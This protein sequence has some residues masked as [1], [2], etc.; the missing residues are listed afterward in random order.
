MPLSA[1]DVIKAGTLN[2]PPYEFEENNEAKGLAVD[3]IRHVF[4]R[5]DDRKVTFLFSSWGRSLLETKQGNQDIL[6][7]A[8]VYE[9]R[10]KWGIYVNSVLIEQQYVFF[11]LKDSNFTINENI[12]N[13]EKLILGTKMH[14][15]Y[16]TGKLRKAL[17]DN[18]FKAVSKV[19]TIEQNVQ[20]LLKKRIDTFVGD[21]LPA[22]HYITQNCL[23][24][25][26]RVIKRDDNGANFVALKWNTYMLISKKSVLASEVNQI[27]S[28]MNDMKSDGTFDTLVEPYFNTA[29]K[30]AECDP[31]N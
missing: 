18:H 8:G 25:K 26:I 12:N 29:N 21:Y 7:N 22:M 16:G 27:N 2:Y 3:I 15:R 17:D 13:V 20:M 24:D 11:A 10:K 23:L 30:Q 14:Y 9:E 5:M 28:V 6:F 1:N 4:S 31:R 19:S